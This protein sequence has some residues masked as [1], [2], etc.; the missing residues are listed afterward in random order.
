MAKKIRRAPVCTKYDAVVIG[1]ISYEKNIDHLQNI[2]QREGGSIVYSTLAGISNNFKLAVVTKLAEKNKDLLN[3]L[4]ADHVDL[5]IKYCKNTTLT[6]NELC[7][8]NNEKV[9][10]QCFCRSTPIYPDDIPN[11]E[12]YFYV[13]VGDFLGD[14][15]FETIKHCAKYGYIALDASCFLKK[16]NP[17]T[18]E[19]YQE[20]YDDIELIA[21]YCD[22][23][24]LTREQAELITGEDDPLEAAKI[25]RS[26]GTREILI[27]DGTLLHLYDENEKYW[28]VAI[29]EFATHGRLYR[30]TTAFMAY[31]GHRITSDPQMSLFCAGATA[32]F[33][34]SRPG[35]ARCNRAEMNMYLE[36]F[37]YTVE[38]LENGFTPLDCF[39]EDIN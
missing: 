25:I 30:G 37:Y 29:K 34:L 21:S 32:M 6:Q 16:V 14:I 1:N 7:G 39:D 28:E 13:F 12:S 17:E 18:K 4:N 3:P 26:W 15:P 20:Y 11:V 10:T 22:I 36:S 23:F 33:K 19:V 9:I 38:I 35:P 27:T 2:E 8:D 5:F 31:V 24:K